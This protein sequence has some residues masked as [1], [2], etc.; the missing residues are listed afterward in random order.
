LC[1]DFKVEAYCAR[2]AIRPEIGNGNGESFLGINMLQCICVLVTA[3]IEMILRDCKI[4]VG[5]APA[6]PWWI[7]KALG[8]KILS[9]SNRN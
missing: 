8:L 2:E 4:P 6:I 7:A 3:G 5:A 1:L 9:L